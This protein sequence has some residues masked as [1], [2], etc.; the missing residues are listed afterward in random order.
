MDK[1]PTISNTTESALW[2]EGQ[3][4][5][6]NHPIKF[7]SWVYSQC[8]IGIKKKKEIGIKQ[9]LARADIVIFVYEV[10]LNKKQTAR[11]VYKQK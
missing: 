4:A 3:G 2:K 9:L 5:W 6:E 7:K 8:I 10:K 1:G 11:V